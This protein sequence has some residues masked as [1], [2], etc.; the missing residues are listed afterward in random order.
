MEISVY[1]SP[2]DA[3][4]L[5]AGD[6]DSRVSRIARRHGCELRP[7]QPGG[8]DPN[9]RRYFTIHI[10]SH[11]DV[12]PLASALRELPDVEVVVKPGAEPPGPGAPV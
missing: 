4:R 11:V 10:Q 5:H 12:A 2:A 9:M 7:V 8:K 3:D 6:S 1:V